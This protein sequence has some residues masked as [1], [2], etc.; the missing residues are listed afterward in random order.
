MKRMIR[1]LA[2]ACLLYSAASSALHAQTLTETTQSIVAPDGLTRWYKVFTPSNLQVPAP[3]VIVLHGGGLDYD[4]TDANSQY[5]W[6][7][8]AVEQGILVIYPNGVS[9][10]GDPAGGSQHWNDCRKDAGTE[11]VDSDDVGFI[12]AML[13]QI[14]SSHAID[15]HRV[16]AVGASNG[17]MMAMRLARELSGR[18][19]AVAASISNNPDRPSAAQPPVD[20]DE[21]APP[22]RPVPIMIT[23]GTG[24]HTINWNGG[25]T[26]SSGCVESA[27]KT[28]DDWVAWNRSNPTP[29]STFTYPDA[30]RWDG[31]TVTC[32]VHAPLFGGAE[33]RFCR[34]NN[35]GHSEPSIAHPTPL[36]YNL[37]FGKGN[38]DIETA[39]VHWEFLSTKSL[40]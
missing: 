8:I 20:N 3:V 37:L 16:Y 32:E 14:E 15:R 2:I 29:A 31:T 7:A 38:R 1:C 23:D 30:Y 36:Y 18:I 33:T 4:E 9:T 25:C 35:G 34:V 10:S 24:D 26:S 28:R 13:D 11:Q 27:E 12:N 6:H 40:P 22:P 5:E 39:R 21:C 19:A 17:G